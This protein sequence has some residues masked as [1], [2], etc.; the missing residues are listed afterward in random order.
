MNNVESQNSQNKMS[1]STPLDKTASA[2]CRNPL[3]I[4]SSSFLTAAICGFSAFEWTFGLLLLPAALLNLIAV[5]VSAGV[6][7][8]N[9]GQCALGFKK[10][11]AGLLVL[12]V[13]V[14]FAFEVLHGYNIISFS[15]PLVGPFVAFGLPFNPNSFGLSADT[16]LLPLVILTFSEW[17]SVC[18]LSRCKIKN[19]PFRG[20]Q[21]VSAILCI[22]ALLGFTIDMIS[23]VSLVLSSPVFTMEFYYV[24]ILGGA[25]AFAV[26]ATLIKIVHL[27]ISFFKIRKTEHAF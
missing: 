17:L 19:L 27:F 21:M 9:N 14:C 2:I 15:K 24:W 8:R 1:I 6:S 25:L 20:G 5:C 13:V 7:K 12:G 4:L 18:S 16:F 11:A 22:L 10:L 23:Y 26:I 3:A